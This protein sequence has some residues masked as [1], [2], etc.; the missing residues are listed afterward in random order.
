MFLDR[1][2]FSIMLFYIFSRRWTMMKFLYLI[3]IRLDWR[4]QI[5]NHLDHVWQGHYETFAW[6]LRRSCGLTFKLH[7]FI[8]Q[9]LT[10]TQPTP[11]N[12]LRILWLLQHL[13]SCE[14]CHGIIVQNSTYHW[15]VVGKKLKRLFFYWNTWN[16]FPRNKQHLVNKVLWRPTKFLK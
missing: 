14:S 8:Y 6:S 12:D 9:Y 10:P 3:R 4:S 13:D 1:I 5:A 15:R 11:V 16:T 7:K 2:V